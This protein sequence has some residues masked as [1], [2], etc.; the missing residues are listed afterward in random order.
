MG[1]KA[2]EKGERREAHLP[3]LSQRTLERGEGEGRARKEGN[4][5]NGP[6]HGRP[7]SG[8]SLGH[9]N[10]RLILA[11]SDGVGVGLGLGGDREDHYQFSRHC[12][13]TC[14]HGHGHGHGTWEDNRPASQCAAITSLSAFLLK[15]H[16]LTQILIH[17]PKQRLLMSKHARIV[18]T[19][20]FVGELLTCAKQ[21]H[22]YGAKAP[23]PLFCRSD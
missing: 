10:R 16:I 4:P 23:L 5:A 21:N 22:K 18:T 3:F 15:Q 17:I 9:R 6:M 1:K 2:M 19:Y 8:R 14:G 20:S 13:V 7:N 11:R 12:V